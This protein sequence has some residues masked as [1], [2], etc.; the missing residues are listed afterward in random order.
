MAIQNPLGPRPGGNA[1]ALDL[2]STT[3]VKSSPGTLYRVSVT[4]A[5]AAGAVYDYA[6]SSGYG[7]ANL[8]GTVPATVGVYEFEWPCAVGIVYVP[9][10]AQ[11]ASISFS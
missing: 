7:A 6:S 11:V 3:V 1:S 10:S 2:S 4:T 5:G 8:I 9:G